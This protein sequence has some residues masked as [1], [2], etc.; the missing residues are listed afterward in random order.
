MQTKNKT[1]EREQVFQAIVNEEWEILTNY[2][3]KNRDEISSDSVLKMAA[4]TFVSEFLSKVEAIPNDT[5][6]LIT[7]ETLYQ[8]DKL[9][10]YKL[11]SFNHKKL[12][13]EIVKRKENKIEEAAKYAKYY[14]DE[15]SCKKALKKHE[16]SKPKKI[17]H[18]Q[19]ESISVTETRDVSNVDFTINLFKSNQE[20]EFFYALKRTFDSYQIYP[21]VAISCLLDWGALK[22]LLS[23]DEKSFFFKGIVDFVVFDQADGFKPLHFFELDSIYH[24]EAE[25]KLR[26]HLKNSIFAKSGVKIIRIRKQTKNVTEPEF[27]R[28]IRDLMKP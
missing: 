17:N 3:H 10:F 18:T 4:D 14:P 15:E 13:I 23:K 19:T 5:Q 1:I 16:D 24:D 6:A 22:D 26:D 8:I 20:I 28:L 21:N 7:L 2:L 25:A 9:N 12:I 11:E 27:I